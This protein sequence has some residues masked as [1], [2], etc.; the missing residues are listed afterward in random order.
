M[1]FLSSS[2]HCFRLLYANIFI[3]PHSLPPPLLVSDFPPLLLARTSATSAAAA[4]TTPA[5]STR[6]S[7]T[8]RSTP[9]P[10]VSP[11][12]TQAAAAALFQRRLA[13]VTAPSSIRRRR[14]R[15]K[16]WVS[17]EPLGKAREY[18][19][20]VDDTQG[21]TNWQSYCSCSKKIAQQVFF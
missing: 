3:S 8:I 17:G 20:G 16:N 6:K 10:S 9:S 14:P 1:R 5:A 2:R 13:R 4:P 21:V 11:G 18:R 7:A 15:V 19:T 12:S